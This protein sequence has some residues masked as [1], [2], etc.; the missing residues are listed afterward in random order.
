SRP[1]FASVGV[2]SD[3]SKFPFASTIPD[4]MFV[5]P[6]SI[7]NTTPSFILSCPI[8]SV[9]VYTHYRSLRSFRKES[10]LWRASRRRFIAVRRV[11]QRAG[12]PSHPAPAPRGSPD[13][14]ADD[15]QRTNPLAHRYSRSEQQIP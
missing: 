3:L 5:P 7:P 14:S 9:L 8:L 12:S 6:I 10:R 15:Q 4:L 13:D 1:D 2:L 11:G